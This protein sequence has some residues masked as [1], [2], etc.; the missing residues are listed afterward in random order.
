MIFI[1]DMICIQDG[2]P[3]ESADIKQ[4]TD[5]DKERDSK[6]SPLR[7]RL[8]SKDGGK[9]KD[10]IKS[11]KSDKADKDKLNSPTKSRSGS[12]LLAADKPERTKSGTL[13]TPK[14]GRRMSRM[15]KPGDMK[16]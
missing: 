10:R 8:N 14:S 5:K 1:G 7:E 12:K 6:D 13:T 15:E 11:A 16:S 2:A 3:P 9:S 4:E